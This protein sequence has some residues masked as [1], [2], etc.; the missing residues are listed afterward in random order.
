MLNKEKKQLI[1]FLTSP[2]VLLNTSP[3]DAIKVPK[4]VFKFI[5]HLYG[6]NIV[7]VHK[8]YYVNSNFCQKVTDRAWVVQRRIPHYM[9]A[10]VQTAMWIY[11][12]INFNRLVL[13]HTDVTCITEN[14]CITDHGIF[15]EDIVKIKDLLVTN[16]SRT[17]IDM[18]RYEPSITAKDLE[19]LKKLKG[20]YEVTEE[21]I[22]DCLDRMKDFKRIEK[23]YDTLYDYKFLT[24]NYKDTL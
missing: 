19:V 2:E 12:G 23:V 17:L 24:Q 5:K 14:V 8:N 21:S 11:T 15:P 6:K 7:E 4:D 22:M 13:N 18:I 1:T 16:P 9:V 20:E 3:G 10:C